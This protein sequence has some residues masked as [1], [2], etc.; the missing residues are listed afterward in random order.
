M[1]RLALMQHYGG[2][3]IN[4]VDQHRG[5]RS[6]E[7]LPTDHPNQALDQID[8]GQEILIFVNGVGVPDGLCQDKTCDRVQTVRSLRL[9]F[10]SLISLHCQC[11]HD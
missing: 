2:R 5:I 4:C 10:P 3:I 6:I 1:R 7:R 8:W 9:R 11:Y